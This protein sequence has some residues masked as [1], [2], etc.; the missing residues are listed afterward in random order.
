MTF[1][2]ILLRIVNEGIR[3]LQFGAAA[4]ILGVF[5]YF[6]AVLT[7]HDKPIAR[8]VKAV[9][10][11]SGAATAYTI[12]GC[13]LTL[14]LGGVS[15]FAGIA[16]ILDIL[17]IGGMVAIAIMTRKGTQSCVGN[18][19]TPLGNGPSNQK[20]IGYGNGGFGIGTGKHATY[21]PSLGFACRLEKTAFAVSIIGAF[22]FLVSI[23][24]QVLLARHRKR[25]MRIGP[26]PRN[27]YTY[28]SSG[29]FWR[30]NKAAPPATDAGD[31]LP[32]HTNLSDMK[33]QDSYGYGNSA[34]NTRNY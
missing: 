26:S 20:P 12:F 8:W 17:F 4:I 25:E 19:N 10:G 2:G 24:F 9:E 3:F 31:A 27:N 22:L 1:G 6:L 21:F 5:S 29:R 18:V 14:C 30:R 16:F 23:F 7:D 34:Y 13:A 11:I 15:F 33:A 32:I 28:G